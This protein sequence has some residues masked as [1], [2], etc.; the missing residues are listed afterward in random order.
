MAAPI[1]SGKKESKDFP[2]KNKQVFSLSYKFVDFEMQSVM[3]FLYLNV[4]R[5]H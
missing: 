3:F 2:I 4:N 1:E 5:V